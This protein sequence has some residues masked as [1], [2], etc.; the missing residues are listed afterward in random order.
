MT[1]FG[2]EQLDV[3][4]IL[5]NSIQLCLVDL[6]TCIY[7]SSGSLRS[8]NYEDRGEPGDVGT[9]QCAINPGTGEE[10]RF[11]SN[12]DGILDLELGW[13]KRDVIDVL[14][15]G[16]NGLSKKQSGPTFVLM[17]SDGLKTIISAISENNGIDQLYIQN[18]YGGID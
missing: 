12:Q 2:T 17:A 16:C 13:E 10:E 1:L 11:S 15:D 4:S 18:V 5:I 8:S 9:S 3:T 7:S 14:L 6:S